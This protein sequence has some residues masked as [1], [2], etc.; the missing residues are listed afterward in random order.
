M[1]RSRKELIAA[2]RTLDEEG[3]AAAREVGQA[4]TL[5]E[6]RLHQIELEMQNLE[7]REAQRQLEESRS[8][9]ADL[10][11]L[12]PVAYCTLDA[13]G[14]VREANREAARLLDTEPAL[15]TDRPL[16]SL[17][18]TDLT[19]FDAHLDDCLAGR[20]RAVCE[21]TL[22]L[23]SGQ[24]VVVQMV[25]T[26][27]G[28]GDAPATAC[29]TTLTDISE[30]KRSEER[31]RMLLSVSAELASSL[32]QRATLPAVVRLLTPPLADLAFVDLCRR[33]GGVERFGAGGVEPVDDYERSAQAEVLRLREPL[34]VVEAQ[35]ASLRAALG[36]AA[37]SGPMIEESLTGSLLMVPLIAHGRALGVFTFAMIHSGRRYTLAERQLA[38]E[39]TAR[40]TMAV[41]SARLYEAAQEAIVAREDIVAIVS[42]DLRNPLHGMRLN[43]DHLLEL[44]PRYDRRAGRKQV[45]AIGRGIHRMSQMIRDLSELSRIEAGH[46]PLERSPQPGSVVLADALDLL[47]P[48]AQQKSLLLREPPPVPDVLLD[49]DRSRV[50]QVLSNLVGNA[51][52]FTPARGTVTL[53]LAV[54]DGFMRFEVRDDGPGIERAQLGHI[55]ERYWRGEER[56]R[57]GSGLGLFIAKAIVDAHGGQIGVDSEPGYGTSVWFTVPIAAAVRAAP[58][59]EPR[60]SVL[61]VPAAPVLVV[62]DDPEIREALADVLASRGY[63]AQTVT[64]GDEALRYLRGS[65]RRPCLILLDLKMPEKDGWAMHASLRADPALA[66]IPVLLLSDDVEIERE[67]ARLGANAC[68]RKPIDVSQLFAA[69]QLYCTDC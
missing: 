2:R 4:A 61:C 24:S 57:R 30:L 39:V 20:E 50:L 38:H 1:T 34:M 45:E 59:A 44:A 40:V 56:R 21:L 36:R 27:L 65:G 5:R 63:R 64:N 66:S 53:A 68:L 7:L 33:D 22:R 29:L 17:V 9:Y 55:F 51:I 46:L 47:R 23:R 49:C 10:Y 6:L 32:D 43:C 26:P 58:P 25:S 13:R 60:V 8:R 67:A 48:L 14:I 54:D 19:R 62:D 52:K 16:M 12:A 69:L 41:E 42:H 3:S 35:A 37:H 15:L 28:S 18:T 11:Q 31:L